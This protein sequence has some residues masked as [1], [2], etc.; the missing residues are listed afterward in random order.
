MIFSYKGVDKI[1]YSNY[2][3]FRYKF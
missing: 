1:K 2:C 3:D